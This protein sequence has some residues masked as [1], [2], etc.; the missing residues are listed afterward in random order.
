MQATK[1]A[2]RFCGQRT[3]RKLFSISKR[4]FMSDIF[5]SKGLK[6][7]LSREV[8]SLLDLFSERVIAITAL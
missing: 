3:V 5:F 4:K 7:I 6:G 2:D 8:L 1:Y